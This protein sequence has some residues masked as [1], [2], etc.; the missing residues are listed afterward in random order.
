MASAKDQGKCDK[1]SV[2]YHICRFIWK[3]WS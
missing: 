3:I 2:V 1:A